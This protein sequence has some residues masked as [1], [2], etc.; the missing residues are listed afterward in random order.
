MEPNNNIKNEIKVPY[1]L[2]VYDDREITAVNKILRS[3]RTMMGDYTKK[4]EEKIAIL[5]GKKFGIMVN[6]GSS[7]NTLAFELLNLPKGSE[8]IT[9]ILTFAT[10]VAPP[11]P[12]RRR[13]LQ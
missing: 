8:V 10:T 5:F 11:F 3:H 7:A 4:F 6:S 9:P 1:A 13:S 2:A 12:P